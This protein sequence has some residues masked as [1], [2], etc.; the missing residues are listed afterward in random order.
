MRAVSLGGGGAG[1]SPPRTPVSV[2]RAAA[3]AASAEG[4]APATFLSSPKPASSTPTTGSSSGT[5]SSNSS[6]NSISSTTHSR[7]AST[8]SIPMPLHKGPLKSPFQY[9]PFSLGPRNCIG[10]RFGTMEASIILAR[11]LREWDVTLLDRAATVQRLELLTVRPDRLLCKLTPRQISPDATP[12]VAAAGSSFFAVE[13][14]M[15][16]GG[17][18]DVAQAC[19]P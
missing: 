5:R 1:V 19:I 7:R 3:A 13:G 18:R 6:N 10:Q 16:G 12:S 11:L 9:V 4:G 17:D 8:S 14:G 15:T 2:H